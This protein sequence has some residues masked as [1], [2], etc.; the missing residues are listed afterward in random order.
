MTQLNYTNFR[1]QLQPF[2]GCCD[3][4][5]M[6]INVSYEDGSENPHVS[7]IL[8][9][10][11]LPESITHRWCRLHF[12]IS[13]VN[14]MNINFPKNTSNRVISDGVAVFGTERDQ[15]LVLCHS[16]VEVLEL[17]DIKYYQLYFRG[18]NIRFAVVNV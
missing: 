13:N 10:R 4:L 18:D 9:C 1:E 15:Y 14:E 3:S 8:E 5:L 7:L 12:S 2:F 17:E 6:Q 11:L 16:G